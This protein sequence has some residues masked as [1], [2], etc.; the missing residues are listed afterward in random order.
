MTIRKK[1]KID[2]HTGRE[3]WYIETERQ[4][5][6]DSQIEARQNIALTYFEKITN[7]LMRALKIPMYFNNKNI[8]FRQKIDIHYLVEKSPKQYKFQV[9][10]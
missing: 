5:K 7:Q 4:K 2:K 3:T 9:L 8:C 6:G 1:S 10:F